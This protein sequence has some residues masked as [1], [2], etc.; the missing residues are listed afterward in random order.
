M[1]APKGDI[2]RGAFVLWLWLRAW[3]QRGGLGRAQGR[4]SR[5]PSAALRSFELSKMPILMPGSLPL[6]YSTAFKRAYEGMNLNSRSG[7]TESLAD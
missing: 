6:P 3:G 1:P 7:E 2:L 5:V 4:G